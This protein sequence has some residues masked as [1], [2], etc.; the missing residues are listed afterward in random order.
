M[1]KETQADIVDLKEVE[2]FF[3]KAMAKGWAAGAK[4]TSSPDMPGYKYISF[5]EGDFSL[6]DQYS[7]NKTNSRGAGS[8]IVWFKGTP[9]W[10]MHYRGIYSKKTMSFLKQALLNA[11]TQARFFGGRGSLI[12]KENSLLYINRPELSEFA[13]FKGREEI[14]DVNTREVLSWDE[15]WGFSLV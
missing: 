2:E 10:V 5:R 14:I 11:Y 13:E 12:L 3:L 4:P 15:Y 6:I 7:F 8:I 9:V 1:K